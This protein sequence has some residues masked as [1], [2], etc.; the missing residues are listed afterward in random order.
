M[1]FSSNNGVQVHQAA[2]DVPRDDLFSAI[3]LAFQYY[4]H[5]VL[6]EATQGYGPLSRVHE[7]SLEQLLLAI[8]DSEIEQAARVA[9]KRH[10]SIRRSEYGRVRSDLVLA[11]IDAGTPYVCCAENC[12]VT[13]DLTIDHIVPLSRGGTDDLS[14]LRF[15]CLPHNSAKGDKRET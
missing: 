3:E 4:Q 5:P 2:L 10:T 6:Q 11:L 15:M 14:N 13:T 7:M 8:R 1:S 9:K 12:N